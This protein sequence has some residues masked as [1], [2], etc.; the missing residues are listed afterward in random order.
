MKIVYCI[1]DFIRWT[2][3]MDKRQRLAFH[4]DSYFSIEVVLCLLFVRGLLAAPMCNSTEGV[5]NCR[6]NNNSDI[7]QLPNVAQNICLTFHKDHNV[8]FKALLFPQ[9][10][11]LHT[12]TIDLKY[13]TD[14][15]SGAFKQLS[16]L[17]N[18]YLQNNDPYR[19][20]PLPKLSLKSG[21]F[22]GLAALKVL[23]IEEIGLIQIESGAF[24]DL[25]TLDQMS[26]AQNK[27]KSVPHFLFATMSLRYL[28]LTQLGEIQVS[29]LTFQGLTKL[30]LFNFHENKLHTL[31]SSIF[32]DMQ[33]LQELNL[34][35]NEI[36][37]IS[38]SAFT[39]LRSLERLYLK[40]NNFTTLECGVFNDLTRLFSLDIRNCGLQVSKQK[41]IICG[42]NS[43]NYS[44]L[45]RKNIS[46][47]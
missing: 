9:L 28:T 19:P 5:M 1:T 20:R 2:A 27:M 38:I 18:L 47:Q 10:P 3:D 32:S 31:E 25:T 37:S 40:N 42:N 39:G 11:A 22:T 41:Y 12:L 8:I 16:H 14:L 4:L 35:N 29:P 34:E 43:L 6:A 15:S 7:Q 24:Q 21:S 33:N 46:N 30:H 17:E 13:V 45:A 44:L 26:I 23:D 36:T